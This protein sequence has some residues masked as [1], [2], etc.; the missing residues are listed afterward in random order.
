MNKGQGITLKTWDKN[1]NT[2]IFKNG[3]NFKATA[4]G[5]FFTIAHGK[6]E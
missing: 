1:G 4:Q 6:T 5:Y 3:G 2:V